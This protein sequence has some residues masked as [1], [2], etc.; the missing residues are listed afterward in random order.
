M[1]PIWWAAPRCCSIARARWAS[2]F[3]TAAI[4]AV[5]LLKKANLDGRLLLFDDRVEELAVSMRDSVLTQ[6]QRVNARGGTNTALPMRQLLAERD[7][8]DNIVL[9]TDEQQ[10]QGPPF[11][12][13]LDQYRKKV[14]AEARVFIL[15]VAPYRNALTGQDPKSWYVYGWSDQALTFISMVSRGFGGMVEAVR[16][17]R[18]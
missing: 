16:G 13:V 9:I 15:D 14:N 12:D 5:S 11:V 6:A 3:Q 8:V 7:R 17:G 2:T 10:N 18:N 4:F 1:F